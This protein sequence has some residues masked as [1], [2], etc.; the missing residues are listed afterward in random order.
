[1][2]KKSETNKLHITTM[3]ANV[4]SHYQCGYLFIH[5]HIQNKHPVSD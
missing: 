1:L 3:N 4:S 2:L 5:R